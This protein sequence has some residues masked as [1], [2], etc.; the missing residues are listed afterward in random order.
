MQSMRTTPGRAP[1]RLRVLASRARLGAGVLACGFLLLQA[2]LHLAVT[3]GEHG[4]SIVSRCVTTAGA[5]VWWATHLAMVRVDAA[6][7][8][9]S[10]ALGGAPADVAVVLA[11]IALPALLAQALVLVA[12]GGVLAALR[13]SWHCARAVLGAPMA[14]PVATPSAPPVARVRTIPRP[15]VRRV[16]VRVGGPVPVRRGPPACA[17]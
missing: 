10:L 15:F 17:A 6:C 5:P 7:P 13:A 1:A 3:L 12:V 16:L 2:C 11:T 9:G 8:E 14:L 4:V